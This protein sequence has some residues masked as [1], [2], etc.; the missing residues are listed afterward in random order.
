MLK[1][2]ITEDRKFH[3]IL[4]PAIATVLLVSVGS[5]SAQGHCTDDGSGP[6][7]SLLDVEEFNRSVQ[8]LPPAAFLTPRVQPPLPSQAYLNNL[9][10]VSQQG[11]AASPGS[12]GSCEA[13]SFGYGLG[14]YT[15]ARLPNGSPKWIA[16]LP[17]NSVSAAYLYSWGIFTGFAQC[18]PGGL[19]LPYLNH[20]VEFGAPTRA[21]VPYEPDCS[22]FSMIPQQRGFPDD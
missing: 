18:P 17:Q 12:P 6:Y 4:A 7:G 21:R 3:F 20:L 14:S 9:P 2:L 1:S 19:A 13:Q 10:A 8:A 15:A 16:A 11:T 22:Y 5:A